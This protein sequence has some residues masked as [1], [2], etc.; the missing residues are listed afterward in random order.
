MLYTYNH[1]TKDGEVLPL[2]RQGFKEIPISLPL[3]AGHFRLQCLFI[4]EWANGYV[5]E[6][7]AITPGHGRWLE[8]NRFTH[9]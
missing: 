7:S 5:V 1:V 9:F 4:P 3:T 6:L 8:L 2:F